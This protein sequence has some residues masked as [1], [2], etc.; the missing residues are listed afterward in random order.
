MPHIVIDYTKNIES[1][2]DVQA[3]VEA[4]HEVT[5]PYG[6]IFDRVTV[7]AHAIDYVSVGQ[8]GRDGAGAY[9]YFYVLDRDDRE[10]KLEI[11][12]SLNEILIN[13]VREQYP[14]AAVTFEMRYMDPNYYLA[15]R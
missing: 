6:A 12:K 5:R 15:Q 11:L 2:V 13:T 9:G 4:L 10:E 3:L 14:Q 7:R 1:K 8:Q